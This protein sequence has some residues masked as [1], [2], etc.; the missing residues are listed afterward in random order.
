[1]RSLGSTVVEHLTLPAHRHVPAVHPK[2]K[3]ARWIHSVRE[4]LK[5]S[6]ATGAC[7]C[8]AC[9]GGVSPGKFGILMYHR[10]VDPPKG[11]P[12]PTWNVAPA[13]FRQQLSGLLKRGF[14]PWSL[15]RVLAT[16]ANGETLPERVF[17]VTFDDGH[18]SVYRRAWPILRELKIPAT[19]FLA[20]AYL[21]SQKRFPFEDWPPAGTDRV[22]ADTWRPMTVAHCLEMATDEA[23]DFGLHT[24]T[25]QEF[26]RR[27]S[28]E[29]S[30]DLRLNEVFIRERL[31]REPI[32][33]A[34][35]WGRTSDNMRSALRQLQVSCGLTT[36]GTPVDIRD[37]TVNWGRFDVA[38]WDTA[39]TLAAKLDGWYSWMLRLRAP[40]LRGAQ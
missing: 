36:V 39:A 23:I 26:S 5:R 4:G 1:M 18:E 38:E 40:E 12:L 17:V 29:F 19:I 27:S 15:Q 20:T 2:S 9:F 8:R 25:H 16:V 11:V 34:F 28:A 13:R 35:P 14:R 22:P 24:H 7:L 33:F 6:V 32:G 37:A 30:T 31:H 21:D 3:R 10:V